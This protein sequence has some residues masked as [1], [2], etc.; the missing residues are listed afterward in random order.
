MR[1]CG[2]SNFE[3]FLN[4]GINHVFDSRRLFIAFVLMIHDAKMV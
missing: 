2:D 1:E 4:D 3:A